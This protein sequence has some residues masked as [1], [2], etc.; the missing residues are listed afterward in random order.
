M[1]TS[2]VA[3]PSRTVAP[4][5]ALTLSALPL[6]GFLVFLVVPYVVNDLDRFTLAEVA[7]GA[8]DPIYSWPYA[9]GGPLATVFGIGAAL[10]LFFGALV[11]V[12][13]GMLSLHGLATEWGLPGRA[14]RTVWVTG[15][16]AMV[17]FLAAGLSPFGIA[18]WAQAMD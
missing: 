7:S 15:L 13:G 16:L 5:L 8:H 14:R 17:A 18:L 1:S 6:V 10:T 9:D 11:S 4:W 12:L 2:T 3:Q